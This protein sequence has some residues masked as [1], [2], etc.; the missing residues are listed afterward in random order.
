VS[1]SR[2][3][4]GAS[5]SDHETVWVYKST[6]R[7]QFE[8]SAISLDVSRE[9]NPSGFG[10]LIKTDRLG[11]TLSHNLTE[12]LSA[13]VS[14]GVYFVGATFTQSTSGAF[15]ESRFT[16]INPNLSW[17]FSPWWTL[18]VG[19]IYSERAIGSVDQ[20]N[21]SNSTFVMLTYGG[22][23]WTMSR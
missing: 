16:S 6:L 3:I 20:W 9:I 10:R 1:S 13:S 11:A 8:R 21:S 19:Y 5:L 15:P 14:G 12:T 7:K 23:K 2:D 18:D 4:S 22:Q 17:K